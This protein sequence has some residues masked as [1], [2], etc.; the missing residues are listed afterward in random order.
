MQVAKDKT[1]AAAES[2]ISDGH[3]EDRQRSS[4]AAEADGGQDAGSG[5]SGGEGTKGGG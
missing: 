4:A 1:G 2:D 3:R 5:E